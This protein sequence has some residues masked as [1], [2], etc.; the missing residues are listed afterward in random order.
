MTLLSEGRAGLGDG[1]GV[2]FGPDPYAAEGFAQAIAEI[3]EAVVDVWG[4]D[5]VHGAS[6][7]AVGL[8]LAK[9]L[10]EHLLADVADELAEM[11]EADGAMLGEDVEDE[12]GPLV[13]D[14]GDDLADEG[15]KGR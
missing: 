6:D 13:G 11:G 3:G 5:G 2:F 8:H 1:F 12:H 10:G 7:E 9:G 14:A 15:F 4:D